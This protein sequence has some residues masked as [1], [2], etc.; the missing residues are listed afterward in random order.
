VS[1]GG[2]QRGSINARGRPRPTPLHWSRFVSNAVAGSG[3]CSLMART[4]VGRPAHDYPA[5][6]AEKLWAFVTRV[7]SRSSADEIGLLAGGVAFFAVLAVAPAMIAL[8][9]VVGLVTDP[10]HTADAAGGVAE[11]LPATARPLVL[12]QLATVAGGSSGSLT[13]ALIVSSATAMW[14]ASG[15]MQKFL[16][17]TRWIHDRPETR[18]VLRLYT[19]AVGLAVGV[20]LFVIVA[21]VLIVGA[22]LMFA[23]LGTGPR[24]L[25]EVLRW[26]VLLA[27]VAGGLTVVY[28]VAPEPRGPRRRAW[29]GSGVA[30]LGWLVASAVFSFYVDHLGS[31][32]RTYGALAGVVVLM[33]WLYLTAYVVLLGAEVNAE[34]ERRAG[35][36]AGT[37]Q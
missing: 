3:S 2:G 30:S 8:L 33:L 37:W 19:L 12:E 14:S 10:A 5:S 22:P 23:H 24:L 16:T 29:P 18:S 21:V 15:S 1:A 34:A 25:A 31:Y 13:A 32:G 7:V 26:L 4:E 9:A 28:R 17:A 27:L 20:A 35:A 11:V 6:R 36:E